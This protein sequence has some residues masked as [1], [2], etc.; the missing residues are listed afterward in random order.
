MEAEA[1]AMG[2]FASRKPG[3]TLDEAPLPIE[4]KPGIC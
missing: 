1:G 2:G 4:K 3:K